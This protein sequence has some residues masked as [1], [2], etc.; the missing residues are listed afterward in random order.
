MSTVAALSEW[1][2]HTNRRSNGAWTQRYEHGVPV[3]NLVPV[4]D[5]GTTGTTV[6]FLPDDALC[7]AAAV[8][9]AELAEIPAEIAVWPHLS[10]EVIDDCCQRP[11]RE[12]GHAR[13]GLDVVR[14][15]GHG[16][17]D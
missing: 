5:D 7:S 8:T 13:V 12:M 2:T 9:A 1:L 4:E 3:T 6:R 11:S 16:L 15:R 14:D 17:H 10:V